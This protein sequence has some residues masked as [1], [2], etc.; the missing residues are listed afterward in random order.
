M[1]RDIGQLDEQ[2]ERLRSGGTLSENEVKAL[3]ETVSLLSLS[4][5]VFL[6]AGAVYICFPPRLL[7]LFVLPF[8]CHVAN[9]RQRRFY[10]VNRMFNQFKHL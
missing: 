3:C 4:S 10:H 8:F 6:C 5:S 9:I 7:S 1:S 2:I